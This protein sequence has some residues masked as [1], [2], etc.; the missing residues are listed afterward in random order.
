[1]STWTNESPLS[2]APSTTYDN[3]AVTY[4]SPLYNY[5]GQLLTSWT[6][7]LKETT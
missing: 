1:M 3:P 7:E 2:G 5:N 6:N 4:D